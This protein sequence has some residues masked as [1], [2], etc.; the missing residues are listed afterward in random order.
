MEP[1]AQRGF[2]NGQDISMQGQPLGP[3]CPTAQGRQGE[4]GALLPASWVEAG[5]GAGLRLGRS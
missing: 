4:G 5:D 2:D 3:P 1:W